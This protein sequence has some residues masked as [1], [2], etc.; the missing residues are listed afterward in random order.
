MGCRLNAQIRK[1]HEALFSIARHE[2]RSL[3]RLGCT[4]NGLDCRTLHWNDRVESRH[5]YRQ[6]NERTAKAGEPAVCAPVAT[7]T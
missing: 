1:K 6:E 2:M 4:R 7:I 3:S 5:R